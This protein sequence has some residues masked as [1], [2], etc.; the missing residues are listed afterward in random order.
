MPA[1]E[2][3]KTPG[4]YRRGNR[5]VVTW[6]H[7]G[8]PKK[9]FFRTYAEAR[10]AKGKRNAGD[11]RP[12]TKVRFGTYF[13]NWIDTYAG[14]TAR[15]FSESTRPEYRRPIDDH[16]MPTWGRWWLGEIE[17]G[18]A[19]ELFGAM[20]AEGKSTSQIKKTKAALSALFGTAVDDGLI[21]SNPVTGVRIP[22]APDADDPEEEGGPKSLTRAEIGLL[23]A[24][25]DRRETE[26]E[27]QRLPGDTKPADWAGFFEFLIH[28][29]LRISEAVGLRWEH[30]VLTGEHPRVKVREQLYKGRRKKLKSRSGKRDVPLS[31]GMTARLLARRRD[32]YGGPAG[33]VFATATG[34]PLTPSNVYSR[35][36]APA[37]IAVGLY[38]EVEIA[39]KDDGAEPKMRKRST[40]SFH[41]FRHTCASLL[42]DAGRNIKQVQEWLGHAD[43]GF[44]LRTY[45]HLM[46]EPAKVRWRLAEAMSRARAGAY[47]R[48]WHLS[49]SRPASRSPT[50]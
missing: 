2:K 7:R 27:R 29:G 17:P 23:L 1:M 21:S 22:P 30:L 36:L 39:P 24:E 33:P 34:T 14:R 9:E 38:L 49:R 8:K 25:V 37:A 20:R 47:C 13:S 6:R 5:Y 42:F 18:D 3:T 4:V 35:V 31:P 15:G 48:A 12:T 16:A 45:V 43:P 19:R 46:D 26:E 50:S 32:H 28:T 10:E 41:T 40:V 44:T 11:R